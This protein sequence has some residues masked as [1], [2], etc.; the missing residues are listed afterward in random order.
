VA[1]K[2]TKGVRYG[3]MKVRMED[4]HDDKY[5]QFYGFYDSIT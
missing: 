2:I 1:A 5:V 4:I 3:G